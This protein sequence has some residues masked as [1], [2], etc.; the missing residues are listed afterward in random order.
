MSKKTLLIINKAQFGYHT[1][2]YKYCQYLQNEFD[3]TYICFDLKREKKHLDGIEVFYIPYEGSF[4]KKGIDFINYC[5]Q[6]I[7]NNEIDLIFIVYFQMVSILKL[8]VQTKRIILDI[9]SGSVNRNL[10]KRKIFDTR[11][12]LESKL[13]ENISII[14]DC[15]RKKL[16]IESKKCYILPLGADTLSIVNKSF[17]NIHLIY[18]GTLNSRNIH[19]TV[20]GLSKYLKINDTEMIEISYDIFGFGTGDEENLLNRT[21]EENGLNTIVKFH[22]RKNHT[23]LKNYFDFCN[24]GVSYIPITDYF[25][26]Q[27]PTKT[28][29]YIN[30]GMLCIG[31]STKLNRNLIT[32]TN[33]VVSSDSPE[34][35][36]SALEKVYNN[37]DNYDSK[38]IR[39]TLTQYSW[40]CIIK[41][42]SNYFREISA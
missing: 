42:L 25:E 36:A 35:F 1:D 29:E 17:Q 7:K 6:H 40:D 30:A 13:F 15:L 32:T 24:I 20:I 8:L 12:S 18:V 4:L 39:E 16:K 21:I 10:V 37:K 23:E 9:R 33:G 19:E 5:R 28:F 27:P 3:I 41:N 38:K 2:T 22:G 14:S 34:S 11:L 26:C 31:T